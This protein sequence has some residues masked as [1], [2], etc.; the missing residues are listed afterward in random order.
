M[1]ARYFLA[2]GLVAASA[3]AAPPGTTARRLAPAR[4]DW[5]TTTELRPYVMQDAL[6]ALRLLRPGALHDR[7]PSSVLLDSPRAP[8]VFVDGMYYGPIAS[9][10]DLRVREIAA[11]RVL[12][13]G[14]AVLRYGA[15]HSAGVI[16]VVTIR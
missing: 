6:T 7:G 13:V 9:L 8:E 2:A 5:L 11:M 14:D 10:R 15:G 1:F 4:T 16:D 12:S 3:C